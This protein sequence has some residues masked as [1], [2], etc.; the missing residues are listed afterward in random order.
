MP[1]SKAQ[2]AA[3]SRYISKH[4]EQIVIRI[5]KGNREKFKKIA[6]SLN[7]SVN[8]MIIRAVNELAREN[9]LE[10]ILNN[11]DNSESEE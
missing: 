8:Q 3:V 11:K 9:A 7:M 5:P 6:D 4:Y 2:K 1:I 10:Y